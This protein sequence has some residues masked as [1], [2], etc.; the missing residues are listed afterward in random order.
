MYILNTKL[1]TIHSS[2]QN[3]YKIQRKNL[4]TFFSFILYILTVYLVNPVL[5]GDGNFCY[6]E[7]ACGPLTWGQFAGVCQFGNFQSPINFDRSKVKKKVKSVN[8]VL[9]KEYGFV[10][11]PFWLR[12]NGHSVSLALT[13]DET[14]SCLVKGKG[15]LPNEPFF[16]SSLHFHWGAD[17]FAGSEHTIDGKAFPLELHMIHKQSNNPS[18]LAVFGILYQLSPVD[19]PALAAIIDNLYLVK[20]FS[21]YTLI[22]P[23]Y[24]L[25]LTQLL[26][27]KVRVFRYQGSLT[28]PTCDEVVIWTVFD[29]IQPVSARQLMAFRTL[30]QRDKRPLRTNYRPVQPAYTSQRKTIYYMKSFTPTRTVIKSKG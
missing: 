26:P 5:C 25:N 30:L 9:S 22:S 12:N 21:N 13:A 3:E 27:K 16:F 8:L 1:L 17:N 23:A 20:E 6:D 10:Y 15:F 24:T 7:P 28:T 11:S 29:D 14:S 19:N 18:Q 2:Q 4:S